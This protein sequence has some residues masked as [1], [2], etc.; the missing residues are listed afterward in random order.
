MEKTVSYGGMKYNVKR[1]GDKLVVRYRGSAV[2]HVV[3]TLT[4]DEECEAPAY[5]WKSSTVWDGDGD[6]VP[7]STSDDVETAVE[8]V[9]ARHA[10]YSELVEQLGDYFVDVR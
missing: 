4:F 7:V 8:E 2:G 1:D 5:A 10:E 6:D 3:P 9:A